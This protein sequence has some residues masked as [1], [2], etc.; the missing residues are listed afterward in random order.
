MLPIFRERASSAQDLD[1]DRYAAYRW[2]MIH[3]Q[4]NGQDNGPEIDLD[5][6]K[7]F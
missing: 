6:L 7:I 5:C 4:Q 3:E 2:I 1:L